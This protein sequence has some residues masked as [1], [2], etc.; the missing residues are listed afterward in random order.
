V[1]RLDQEGVLVGT[2]VA[3]V[4][5]HPGLLIPSTGRKRAPDMI[6]IHDPR[7][8]ALGSGAAVASAILVLGAGCAPEPSA[9]PAAAPTYVEAAPVVS[10][11]AEPVDGDVVYVDAPPV[12]DID[13]YP[14]VD[15]G[16]VTVYYVG[17]QWYRRGPR[18]WAYYRQEPVELGRQRESHAH[19]ERW[20]RARVAPRSGPAESAP[21]ARPVV[22]APQDERRGAPDRPRVEPQA[23][24]RQAAPEAVEP[25]QSKGTKAPSKDDEAQVPP[26][27][28]RG[29]PPVKRAPATPERR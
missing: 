27:K 9:P 17:G 29:R 24:E 11:G 6:R 5:A 23:G 21:P 12:S 25:A 4:G 14:S 3:F 28:K 7:M 13:A 15:Y 18:G 1:S 19:D 22:V 8:H 10:S 2:E 16:G 20:E 26:G